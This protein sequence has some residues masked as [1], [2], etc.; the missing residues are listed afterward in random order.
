MNQITRDV[1]SLEHIEAF[2]WMSRGM[3]ADVW[4]LRTTTPIAFEDPEAGP[5]LDTRVRYYRENFAHS[6]H[7][8]VHTSIYSTQEEALAHRELFLEVLKYPE[9]FRLADGNHERESALL[10]FDSEHLLNSGVQLEQMDMG[11]ALLYPLT[12]QPPGAEEPVTY[13]AY[14][15]GK[16]GFTFDR[17]HAAVFPTQ[18]TAVERIQQFRDLL[19][20]GPDAYYVLTAKYKEGDNWVTEY[21]PAQGTSPVQ[22]LD[23]AKRYPGAEEALEDRLQFRQLFRPDSHVVIE[24]T[25]LVQFE[26]DPVEVEEAIVELVRTRHS[27]FPVGMTTKDA[28][29]N[30]RQLTLQNPM[31]EV[32]SWYSLRWVHPEARGGDDT[33]GAYYAGLDVMHSL[34]AAEVFEDKES[35][36]AHA[37]LLCEASIPPGT[38]LLEDAPGEV[39]L[40][41]KVLGFYEDATFQSIRLSFKEGLVLQVLEVNEIEEGWG[42]ESVWGE[43][44]EWVY[45]GSEE[46]TSEEEE[47]DEEEEGPTHPD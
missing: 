45:P 9:T 13:T 37:K 39:L 40:K 42:W 43:P 20:C 36:I 35:A 30:N 29:E 38:N 3:P 1:L 28:L 46:S 17:Q 2:T 21:W 18:E 15:A 7:S 44:Y 4:S 11:I 41:L 8:S 6:V 10:A 23:L 26:G 19:G 22:N 25:P 27:H 14:F 5:I 47:D 34:E 31:K 16:Y 12:V 32:S 24:A 33:W